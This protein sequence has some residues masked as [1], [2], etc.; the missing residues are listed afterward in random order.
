MTDCHNMHK[1]MGATT[2]V[3]KLKEMRQLRW[4]KTQIRAKQDKQDISYQHNNI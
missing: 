1:S 4:K 3:S 2:A